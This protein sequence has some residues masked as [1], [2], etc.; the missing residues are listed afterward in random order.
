M[1]ATSQSSS[2]HG[3]T[4]LEVLAAIFLTSVITAF[5]VG[6]YINLSDSSSRATEVMREGI[7][8][9]AVLNRIARDLDSATLMVKAEEADPLTHPWYF[10][11]ESDFAFDGADRIKFISRNH[12]PTA[13][14]THTSDL[15]QVAYQTTPEEDE[16][17]SLYRW[18]SPALPEGYDGSF[19]SLDDPQSFIVAEGLSSFSMQ[20]LTSEGEWVEQWDST[21]LE[22]SGQ[23]PM[24]I[25]I[26]LSLSTEEEGP[27]DQLEEPRLYSRHLNLRNTPINL[28]Q[29][30][31]A[32]M[33]AENGGPREARRGGL[34]NEEGIDLDGDG[35]PDVLSGDSNN[36]NSPAAPGS[37]ADCIR[38]NWDQCSTRFGTANCSQWSTLSQSQVSSF[39][40]DLSWCQ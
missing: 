13:S 17:L 11:A 19:P 36:P 8:A 5:A 39:G 29:M 6:F 21:Q 10:V 4:L 12:K 22:R 24:G 28:E 30:L 18:I 34:G 16:T 3:F 27:M 23:L 9:T 25:R 1:K 26:N 2:V 14:S 7:R 37:V 38:K 40:I 31:L 20:F 15:I 32:K 35:E 33:E